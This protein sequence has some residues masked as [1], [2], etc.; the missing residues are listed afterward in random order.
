VKHGVG[1]LF[2]REELVPVARISKT[3]KDLL[4]SIDVQP[5]ALL[6]TDHFFF[7]T[8]PTEEVGLIREELR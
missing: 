1:D 8:L 7:T 4:T 3:E 6:V 2:D 5:Y